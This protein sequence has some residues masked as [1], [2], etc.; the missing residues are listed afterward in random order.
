MRCA[1]ESEHSEVEELRCWS[2]LDE[3]FFVVP[4]EMMYMRESVAAALK[5]SAMLGQY[6]R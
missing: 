5:A 6:L 4:T 3:L 2:H 1:E